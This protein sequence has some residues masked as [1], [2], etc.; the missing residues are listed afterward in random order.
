MVRGSGHVLRHRSGTG[1][2]GESRAAMV[3][4]GHEPGRDREPEQQGRKPD[5]ETEQ[6]ML[7]QGGADRLHASA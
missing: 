4:D 1:A 3:E 6:W 7:E 5:R 2:E